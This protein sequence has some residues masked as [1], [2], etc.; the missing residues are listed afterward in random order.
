MLDWHI[1]LGADEAIGDLPLNRYELPTEKPKAKP[2][3]APEANLDIPR[4]KQVDPVA[5][6]REAANA[7]TDLPALAQAMSDFDHCALK[8]GARSFVFADGLPGA[9]V[10]IIGEAP[11]R[12]EDRAGQPFVAQV[13][14]LLDRMLGAIQLSRGAENPE[15]AVYLTSVVPWRPPQN[16]PPE[17]ADLAM[18]LPFLQRHITLAN[19]DVLILMGNAPCQALMGHSGI[20]RMRGQWVEVLDRPAL[21]MFH[22]DHLLRQPTAKREAWADLLML[23]AHLRGLDT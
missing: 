5:E 1:E 16:R 21:P 22:P 13:G 6:A 9:R 20:T 3:A 10:M 12:D 4:P 23:K 14:A 15:S 19:P 7:A 18:M 8:Q 11:D 2:K 17:K